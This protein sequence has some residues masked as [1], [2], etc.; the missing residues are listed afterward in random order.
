MGN[1]IPIPVD[2]HLS[3]FDTIL[4]DQVYDMLKEKGLILENQIE[5]PNDIQL[6]DSCKENKQREKEYTLKYM[7][8]VSDERETSNEEGVWGGPDTDLW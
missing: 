7:G 1:E 8:C 3:F 4:L 5:I 6:I 2:T